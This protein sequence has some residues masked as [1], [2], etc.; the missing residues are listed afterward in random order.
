[1]ES[2][3]LAAVV[4]LAVVAGARWSHR[5]GLLTG[6]TAAAAARTQE[7]AST[8]ALRNDASWLLPHVIEADASLLFAA[9]QGAWGRSDRAA[10][11]ALTGPELMAA[12]G[13]R[14]DAEAARGAGNRVE[15]LEGPHV[16]YVGVTDGP[17]DEDE[18]VV[19]MIAVVRD[20]AVL[21]NGKAVPRAKQRHPPAA[22]RAPHGVVR[23]D[24]FWTLRRT[25]SRWI[26]VR[27][28]H[29]S[30]GRHHVEGDARGGGGLSP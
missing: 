11:A 25:G 10:L 20:E 16:V 21:P 7:E 26:V 2:V 15:V 14:L 23:L 1:M 19:E 22:P 9:V 30:D 24:E 29:R 12:W 6:R 13:R 4:V 28:E 3:L 18:V 5:R 8:L 17:G 27:V